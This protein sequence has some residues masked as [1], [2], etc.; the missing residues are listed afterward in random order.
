[1]HC[2]VQFELYRNTKSLC[3]LTGTNIILKVNYTSKT[4]KKKK[5]HLIVKRSDLWL[6]EPK[7]GWG[8]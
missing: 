3:C 2:D 8:G 6:P 5:K 4:Q 1:M 7:A